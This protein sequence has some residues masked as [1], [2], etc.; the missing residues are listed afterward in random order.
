MSAQSSAVFLER[1]TIKLLPIINGQ[2]PWYP[3]SANYVLTKKIW[4]VG[5]VIFANAFA[6]THLVK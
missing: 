6:S 2:L 4:I 1:V 3:E 5:A